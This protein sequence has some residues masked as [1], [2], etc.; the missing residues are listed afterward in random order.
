MRLKIMKNDL[1]I[2][3]DLASSIDWVSYDEIISIADD[4]AVKCWNLISGQVSDLFSL[5][6]NVFPTCMNWFPGQRW[7]KSTKT[8]TSPTECEIFLLGATDGNCHIISK[9]GR[10]ERTVVAHQGSVLSAKWNFDG[11]SFATSGEDGQIKIWSRSGMLRSTLCQ[12]GYPVYSIAWGTNS[13]TML[14]SLDKQLVMQPLQANIKPFAWKAHDGV[15]LQVDWNVISDHLISGSEDCKYKVWDNF[16]RL[17]YSSTPFEYPVTSLSWSPDGQLFAA[18]SYATLVLCDKLGWVHALEKTQTGSILS[19]K[20]STDG[21]QIACAGGNGRIICGQIVN[22][23]IEWNGFEACVT[24]E[25][26]IV[27]QNVRNESME[28]LEFRDRVSKISFGFNYFITVTSTQ[29]YVYN[30]KNFNTPTIFDLKECN[31]TH[32]FQCQK[33]FALADGSS[34]YVYNYDVRLVCSLKPNNM[35]TE[36]IY[37][38]SLSISNDVIVIKDQLDKKVIHLFDPSSG[39]MLGDGKPITHSNEI[40]KISLNQLGNS[41]DRRLILLDKNN[42]LYLMSVRQLGNKRKMIK[43]ATMVSSCLWAETSNILAAITNDKLVIWFYPDIALTDSDI[44]NLTKEEHNI[45]ILID[46]EIKYDGL[47]LLLNPREKILWACLAG[48]ATNA[49]ILDVAEI[50]F[51][52]I[53]EVDKVEYIRYIKSLPTKEMQ[54]AEMLILSEAEGVLL[55]NHLYFRAIMLNLHAFKWNRALELANKHDLA[56]D[57]VLSMRHIYLQQMNRAEELDSFNSQPK[58]ILLDAIKLKER[59][60]EEYLNEQKQIQQLSNS[61]KP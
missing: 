41:F 42:D 18:G 30:I 53:E 54:N 43:L 10:I 49:K 25:R 13:N 17:L 6:P 15:I 61:D 19:I 48:L 44:F 27:L 16:G 5:S 45:I 33:Y 7:K 47:C 38:D 59:I 60:D 37:E 11:T 12:N 9:E 50:A 34:V 32:I 46:K 21:N 1:A 36:Q 58:Q 23:C 22:R 51:A 57:I 55:H 39:K 31:V 40:I 2:H 56:I 3:R 20:W 52:E 4:R 29:C 28:R 8:L 14:F 35:R 26:T 24:D